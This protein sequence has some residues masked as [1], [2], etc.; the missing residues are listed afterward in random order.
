HCRFTID[1]NSPSYSTLLAC[2]LGAYSGQSS[3]YCLS[4][5]PSP[6]TMDPTDS[7]GLD[8]WYPDYDTAF[9]D[10]YCINTRPMP[11]NGSRPT[12]STMLACCKGAYS[13]QSSGKCLS[14]LLNP[15][16]ISP[17][18]A[19]GLDVWYADY[20]IM[21]YSEGECINERPLPNGRTV[22][23]SQLACCNGLNIFT[24]T[25]KCLSKL[26]NPPTAY[27]TNAGG[28]DV[29]YPDYT[30][31]YAHATCIN[32]PPL[33]NGI[34]TYESQA[35]CCNSVYGSQFSQACICDLPNPP[36]S[37]PGVVTAEVEVLT[38]KTTTIT[39]TVT[40]SSKI[41]LA[42]LAMPTDET[43]KQ[44]VISTLEETI[45]TLVEASL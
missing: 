14:M 45:K 19:G 28:L 38:T 30:Q 42:G 10:A 44:A 17:T 2:C 31:A 23:D 3:G 43:A 18:G 34:V 36:S 11:P 33:P 25:G 7:G 20:S 22:Y 41:T 1:C 9:A 8:E 5:L 40:V 6:P 32:D 21:D 29:W 13:G 26:P 4:Q 15:P 12:F 16:T 27:P 24:P 35:V 39:T 37:C